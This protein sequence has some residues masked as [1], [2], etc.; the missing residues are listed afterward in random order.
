MVDRKLKILHFCSYSWEIGGP[1]SV[2]FN[3]SNSFKNIVVSD[4]AS[5]INSD[6]SLYSTYPGQR[7][8]VFK[9]SFISKIIPDFSL[10]SIVWFLKYAKQ[11]DLVVIHGLWNFGSFLALFISKRSRL[12]LTIHG[13]LDPYVMKKSKFKKSISWFLF[14]KYSFKKATIIHAISSQEENLLVNKFPQFKNKIKFIPNGINDPISENSLIIPN[15]YL[16]KLIDVFLSDSEYTF[17]YLGRINEKKGIDLIF[18]AFFTLVNKSSFRKIKLIIAGPV[19]NYHIEFEELKNRFIHINILILPPV[20]SED[21]KY[22][23]SKVDSFLLPSYSEGFSIAALEAIA[24]GKACVFSENIGFSEEALKFGA[25]L[26]CDLNIKSLEEKMFHLISN[27]DLNILL[28]KNS[29]SF[30]LNNYQ[31]DEIAN[32]YYNEIII[33]DTR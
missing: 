24:Y 5:T 1:P 13:F 9:K 17:L 10:K 32:R 23:F 30:F 14:Q 20:I 2:I 27:I 8:F 3:L 16:K 4:I 19:D 26:I 31:I 15:D 28:K 29:R 18:E 7:I 33:N 11:Y 6:H 25:A 12:V 22:L 21:K